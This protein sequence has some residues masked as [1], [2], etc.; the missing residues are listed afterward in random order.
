MSNELFCE[1]HKAGQIKRQLENITKVVAHP[2]L[3]PESKHYNM[4]DG[5][6]AIEIL[7]AIMTTTEL[8]AW[9]RGNIYKYRLRLGSKDDVFKEVKKIQTYEA[10][11]K[12]LEAKDAL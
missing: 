3:N 10:Y 11:Y 12:F 7:E 9:C 8:M 2:L 6:E 4:F 5:K 1:E